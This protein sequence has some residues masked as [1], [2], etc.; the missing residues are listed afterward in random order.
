MKKENEE[1]PLVDVLWE[2][3]LGGISMGGRTKKGRLYRVVKSSERN[4]GVE[5]RSTAKEGTRLRLWECACPI[6]VRVSRDRWNAHCDDCG[7]PY[8]LKQGAKH[9]WVLVVGE[10]AE[11]VLGVAF[12][13]SLNERKA[14]R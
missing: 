9:H 13:E 10:E 11:K 8:K 1:E 2:K 4:V 14:R 12:M 5:K 6:K 3:V 7:Q